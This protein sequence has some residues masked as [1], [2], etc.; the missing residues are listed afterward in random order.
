MTKTG[1]LGSRTDRTEH[2]TLAPVMGEVGNCVVG[3]FDRFLVQRES[4]V[5][6][7]ELAQRHGRRA[8]RVCLNRIRT[9]SK[10]GAMNVADQVGTAAGQDFRAVLLAPVILLNRQIPPLQLGTHAAIKQQNVV[11]KKIEQV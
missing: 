1:E 7:I 10:E 6:E 8:E 4:L 5:G 9:G 2:E 3:Q 11:L